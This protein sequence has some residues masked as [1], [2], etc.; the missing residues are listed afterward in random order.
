LP[1]NIFGKLGYV[2]DVGAAKMLQAAWSS[3][4]LRIARACCGT[5]R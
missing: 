5:M 2:A 3:R 4:R 1:G